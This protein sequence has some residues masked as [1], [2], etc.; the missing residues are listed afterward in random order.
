MATLLETATG[1]VLVGV[2]LLVTSW[3]GRRI[4]IPYKDLDGYSYARGVWQA[5]R[6]FAWV[7][8]RLAILGCLIVLVGAVVEGVGTV[9]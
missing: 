6:F 5:S 1:A 7:G 2:A 4:S 3:W 9:L 8:L